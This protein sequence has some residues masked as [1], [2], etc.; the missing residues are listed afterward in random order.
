MAETHQFTNRLIHEKSPYLLQHAHN[1]VDWYPWGEEAFATAKAQNKPIF[2]SIG[3]AT[4]H[5]CHVMED[6]SFRDIEVAKALNEVFISIKVDREELPEIDA[7]YM[8]FA[9]TMIVGAAGWPLNLIL[10]PELKPFFA[11]TYLP[12][13]NSRGLIGLIELSSKIDGLWKGETQEKIL[14]QAE[15]IV[16]ILKEHLHTQGKEI[17][18][19]EHVRRT[20]E[21]LFKIADPI[22]GGMHG[23]PK[24]PLGYQA[25]FLLHYFLQSQDNRALF[26]VEKTLEMM[27]RGGIYDHLGG[28]LH[29]YSVDEKWGVP[30]F[31]KMLYD[32]AILIESYLETWRVTGRD[33]Y[34]RVC[35]EILQYILRDMT[36]PAGGFYS[37]ED[38]DTLGIEG[39]FY[40][41]RK[42]EI[43]TALGKE[44]GEFFCDFYGVTEEG[45]FEGRSVLSME[46]SLEEFSEAKGVSL[47]ECEIIFEKA[48]K[49]LFRIR[50]DRPHPLKDDKIITAWN[51]LMIQSFAHA[52]FYLQNEAYL[53]AALRAARFLK[54]NLWKNGVLYRRYREG[55]TRYHGG[56]DDYAFLVSG[57]LSLFETGCGSEW[58]EWALELTFIL[59]RDFKSLDGAFYQTDGV[60]T[61]ILLRKC[62]F[63]DGAEP[64]GNAVH[65]EN[66]LRLYQITADQNY[67]IQAEDIFKAAQRYID[68]YP[69]GYCYHLKALQR[70]YDT[71]KA[72]V[73]I[74]F[75]K[76]N[77]FREE[78]LE[79][80]AHK[81]MPHYTLIFRQKDDRLESI[82]PHSQGL[83]PIST[84]TTVSICH[85][86]VCHKSLDDK[87][88]IIKALQGL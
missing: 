75:N 61:S 42:E 59:E 52:G 22:Y 46:G 56:L 12:K 45:N 29:R 48:R 63:A 31:E 54:E 67:L 4:C 80:L 44:E 57:L 19:V 71:K 23:A 73:V 79:V 62:H 66:L 88:S 69:L 14:L 15:K 53:Q 78:I 85:E 84:K 43:L 35:H 32:N 76:Q 39:L 20:A 33:L 74:T 18:A 34:S 6:E 72:C 16:A 28:G 51:G 60:D 49:L 40:T 25:V 50:E 83:I 86:G 24:F 1:P 5:W 47:Q 58:L 21:I 10:T 11:T 36:S 37:A 9:Q 30:H 8:E 7:L 2:L 64:S 13:H 68:A 38:A 26:L 81:V 82:I 17:T 27:H 3:Y 70:Y 87:E 65:A 77:E 41:W 55:D